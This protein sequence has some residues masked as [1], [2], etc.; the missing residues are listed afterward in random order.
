MGAAQGCRGSL[1]EADRGQAVPDVLPP[2]AMS[3]FRSWYGGGEGV[4][5]NVSAVF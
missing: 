2:K 5:G 3:G 4:D 1:T